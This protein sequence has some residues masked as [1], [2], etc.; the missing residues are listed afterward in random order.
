MHETLS[1]R[2]GALV[3]ATMTGGT[4]RHFLRAYKK[5]DIDHVIEPLPQ[6]YDRG[7]ILI[8]TFLNEKTKA[9]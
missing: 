4:S 8:L 7:V 6:S 9:E 1:L 3:V 2:Q 5:T